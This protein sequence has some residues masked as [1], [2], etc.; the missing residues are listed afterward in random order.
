MG[1]RT[2]VLDGEMELIICADG[3]C[4]L[5]VPESGEMGLITVVRD[6]NVDPYEGRYIVRPIFEEQTLETRDKYMRDDVT[7]EAIEVSRTSNPS[8]GTT[9]YIGGSI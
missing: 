9:V 6:T 3:E 8:G 2:V 4:S 7:V 5:E 1:G